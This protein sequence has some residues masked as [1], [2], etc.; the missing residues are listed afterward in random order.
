MPLDVGVAEG[1]VMALS[2]TR[3]QCLKRILDVANHAQCNGMTT[4]DMGWIDIY[5]NDLGVVRIKL[6]L[7]KIGPKKQKRVE[8]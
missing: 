8:I 6:T 5:L 3:Q 4:P 2:N 1:R 7:R